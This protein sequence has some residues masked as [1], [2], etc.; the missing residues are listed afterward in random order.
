MGARGSKKAHKRNRYI[1]KRVVRGKQANHIKKPHQEKCGYVT[2]PT[3]VPRQNPG[4]LVGVNNAHL[5]QN[6]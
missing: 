2:I 1:L 6:V 4:Q 3:G 5:P